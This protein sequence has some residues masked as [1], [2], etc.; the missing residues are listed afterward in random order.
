MSTGRRFRDVCFNRAKWFRR[1]GE[2]FH[3]GGE[4]RHNG[5]VPDAMRH[6]SCGFARSRDLYFP[7]ALAPGQQQL[8]NLSDRPRLK[9]AHSTTYERNIVA[10]TAQPVDFSRVP[11]STCCEGAKTSGKARLNAHSLGPDK[12]R[13]A[14]A[15]EIAQDRGGREFKR[16]GDQKGLVG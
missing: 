15:R 4:G 13:A 16:A 6:S 5:G 2:L 12:V 9:T 1:R 7:R 8:H 10:L 11:T 3:R 14:R